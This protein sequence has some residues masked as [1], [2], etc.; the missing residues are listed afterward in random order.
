MTFTTA[1]HPLLSAYTAAAAPTIKQDIFEWT[2]RNVRLKKSQYS[3]TA[4]FDFTPWFKDPVMARYGDDWDIVNVVAGTGA[5]K[6]TMYEIMMSYDTTF[7]SGDIL[8]IT[9]NDTTAANFNRDRL[10]TTLARTLATKDLFNSLPD[11]AKTREHINFPHLKI[12]TVGANM[13]SVQEISVQTVYND[14]CFTWNVGIMKEA[15]KRLHDRHDG[16][17][18]N[19]SQA[20]PQEGR[21]SEWYDYAMKGKR[22]DYGWRCECEVHNVWDF[23]NITFDTI[24]I[25]TEDEEA[26][27]INWLETFDTIK[28]TC[29]SCAKT[30]E[31]NPTDRRALLESS[32]FI[33]SDNNHFPRVITYF[34]NSLALPKI[35]WSKTVGEFLLAKQKSD[36][37]NILPLIQ[38]KNKVFSEFTK[39]HSRDIEASPLTLSDYRKKDVVEPQEGYKR[40]MICDTQGGGDSDQYYWGSIRDWKTDGSGDSRLVYESMIADKAQILEVAEKYKV[41]MTRL[42]IDAAYETEVVLEWC[43]EVGCYALD[44]RQVENYDH[45]KQGVKL[46]SEARPRW[47]KGKKT[48]VFTYAVDKVKDILAQL[49]DGEGAKWELPADTSKNYKR[50]LAAEERQK[51]AKTGKWTWVDI[52][53][54]HNH[55]LDT[56][57]MSIIAAQI[58]KCF[59]S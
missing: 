53:N 41:G 49:K 44:G 2:P 51:S 33:D 10:Q 48:H 35:R 29:P 34:I 5:G 11:K 20:G 23:L 1:Q 25:E 8:Y 17:M 27:E 19:V 42:F 6:S 54:G 16:K 28:L 50:H 3:N 7:T 37:G 14:E 39:Q 43:A 9:Q 56:E 59:P 45:G 13:S 32:S 12:H 40:I 47:Y 46:Y 22:M 55:L 4:S 36:Q 30:Y 26:K 18:M 38:L 21:G 57:C 58:H 31:D 52:D 15:E 24:Y